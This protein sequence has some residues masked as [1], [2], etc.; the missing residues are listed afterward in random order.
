M[1]GNF[2]FLLHE[3]LVIYKKKGRKENLFEIDSILDNNKICI[4][5]DS[6][7]QEN[8]YKFLSENLMIR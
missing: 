8:F 4:R 7:S 2:F 3:F 1:C 6:F 5:Q